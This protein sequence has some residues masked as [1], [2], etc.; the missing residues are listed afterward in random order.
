MDN[1]LNKKI[2]FPKWFVI[3]M[4]VDYAIVIPILSVYTFFVIYNNKGITFYGFLL[5]LFLFGAFWVIKYLFYSVTAT[6]KGLVTDSKFGRNKTVL[7]DEIVEI[8]RH[9]FGIPYEFTSVITKEGKKLYLL[10]SMSHYKELIEFIKSK[11][12]NL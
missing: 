7:W 12:I 1:I 5:L 3:F 4:L 10:R 11:A 2:G 8:R 9:R 6:S